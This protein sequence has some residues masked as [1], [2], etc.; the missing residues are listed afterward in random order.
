MR[1][2]LLHNSI[3]LFEAIEAVKASLTTSGYEPL[4]HSCDDGWY[5]QIELVNISSDSILQEAMNEAL[6]LSLEKRLVELVS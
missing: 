3:Y 6:A 5:L 2:K 1:S 4:I